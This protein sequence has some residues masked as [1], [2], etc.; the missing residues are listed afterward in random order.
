MDC[1]YK[2]TVHRINSFEVALF[3]KTVSFFD[4]LFPVF[5]KLVRCEGANAPLFNLTLVAK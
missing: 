1:C 4:Q 2:R 5:R 3:F